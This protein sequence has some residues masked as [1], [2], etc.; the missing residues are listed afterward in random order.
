MAEKSNQDPK[1]SKPNNGHPKESSPTAAEKKKGGKRVAGDFQGIDGFKSHRTSPKKEKGGNRVPT[2][3]RR[4]QT[5]FNLPDK[6]NGGDEIRPPSVSTK[7]NQAGNSVPG[8][9]HGSDEIGSGS[10][11]NAGPQLS[12]KVSNKETKNVAADRKS[13]V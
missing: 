4:F 9:L 8:K 5:G 7:N 3:R 13:V 10:G 1:R 2:N 11:V 6:L 12:E